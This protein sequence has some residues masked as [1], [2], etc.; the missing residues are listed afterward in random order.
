MGQMR[1]FSSQKRLALWAS[2]TVTIYVT[3]ADWL[4]APLTARGW[5]PALFTSINAL[6]AV[7][8]F[9]GYVFVS[10]AGLRDGHYTTPGVWLVMLIVNAI[11]WAVGLRIALRLLFPP[12]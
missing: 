7:L 12:S 4:I 5:F 11:M 6:A 9:P 2:A 1:R 10:K 3:V 8:E